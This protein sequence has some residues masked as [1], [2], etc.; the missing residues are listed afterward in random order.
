[1]NTIDQIEKRL[2]V[3]LTEVIEAVEEMEENS[4]GKTMAK[5]NDTVKKAMFNIISK[6]V[7]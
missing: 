3:D 7:G 2:K 1:M 5:L 6:V 4:D